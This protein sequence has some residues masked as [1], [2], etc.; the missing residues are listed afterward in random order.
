MQLHPV[1]RGVR[2]FGVVFQGIIL[3]LHRFPGANEII[4]D[5]GGGDEGA[6]GAGGIGAQLGAEEEIGVVECDIMDLD[7]KYVLP[8]D[9]QAGGRIQIVSGVTAG[10]AGGAGD[11]IVRGEGIRLRH[12]GAG[13]LHPVQIGDK[14]I[15]IIHQKLQHQRVGDIS[16]RRG[17]NR[18]GVE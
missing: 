1:E 16:C 4:E 13:D 15:I 10:G 14:S 11:C 5:A 8:L 12:P 9:E 18:A 7:G 17:K 6:V 2:C 3:G